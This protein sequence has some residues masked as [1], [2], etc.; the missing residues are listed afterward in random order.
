M[1]LDIPMIGSATRSAWLTCCPQWKANGLCPLLFDGTDGIDYNATYGQYPSVGT[2]WWWKIDLQT[3]LPLKTWRIKSYLTT[4]VPMNGIIEGSAT[5]AFAGEQTLVHTF[6]GLTHPGSEA[7]HKIAITTPQNFRYFRLVTTALTST[8]SDYVYLKDFSFEFTAG[9]YVIN[10][11]TD[12]VAP[13]YKLGDA[14][15][16]YQRRK[17]SAVAETRFIEA[18][19]L[20]VEDLGWDVEVLNYPN[21]MIVKTNGIDSDQ[22][23]AYVEVNLYGGYFHF[24]NRWAY[25]DSDTKT[26]ALPL[27]RQTAYSE[28]D[29][30]Y[31]DSYGLSIWGNRDIAFF[32]GA[33]YKTSNNYKGVFFMGHLPK[34][35]KL[36][37]THTTLTSDINAGYNATVVVENTEKFEQGEYYQIWGANG[38]GRDFGIQ[39][40]SITDATHIVVDNMPRNYAAG[41]FIGTYPQTFFAFSISRYGFGQRNVSGLA[42]GGN[43]FSSQ[44]VPSGYA[45]PAGQLNRHVLTPQWWA[46]DSGVNPGYIALTSQNILA[47]A[48]ANFDIYIIGSKKPKDTGEVA[49]AANSSLTDAA[50]NWTV[51]EH[52]G[53]YVYISAGVGLKD[54]GNFFKISSNTSDTLTI[55]SAWITNPAAGD[56]YYIAD[57]IWQNLNGYVLKCGA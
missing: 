40:T 42:A 48:G 54:I 52:A 9:D 30:C 44:A 4:P 53:R 27:A 47:G 55:N 31:F 37:P 20:F 45:D 50:K 33:A 29:S 24:T 41:A 57:E 36:R 43:T 15:W 32:G 25:W 3:A 51:D 14:N 16:H 1:I 12:Y 10:T 7:L 49:S 56:T 22:P 17:I 26:G 5:G 18:A 35:I 38:E 2:P 39:V 11:V 23:W 21:S 8:T 6:T 19:C 46:D 34:N 13:D 28:Y